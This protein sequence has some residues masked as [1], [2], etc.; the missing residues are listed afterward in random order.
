MTS[1][2]RQKRLRQLEALVEVLV[3]LGWT[4]DS[5]ITE[6]TRDE[7]F[8]VQVNLTCDGSDPEHGVI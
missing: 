7:P 8:K 1:E 6:D 3:E 5:L 2:E 4:L